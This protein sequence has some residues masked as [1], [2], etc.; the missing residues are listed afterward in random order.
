MNKVLQVMAA[1]HRS[2]LLRHRKGTIRGPPRQTEGHS[3]SHEHEIPFQNRL[4]NEASHQRSMANCCFPFHENSP[5]SVNARNLAEVTD[6]CGRDMPGFSD[7]TITRRFPKQ[8][9]QYVMCLSIEQ[10]A[11][12]SKIIGKI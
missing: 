6:D 7:A 12:F 10:S 2:V 5:L 3:S 8:Q 9:T 4:I 1:E 11:W